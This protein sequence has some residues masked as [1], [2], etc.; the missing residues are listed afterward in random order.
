MLD[1][2]LGHRRP[3]VKHPLTRALSGVGLDTADV[4]TRLC[5]DPKTVQRW[6][7]G[8]V[9]YPRHRAAL[10]ELTGWTERDLWPQTH[11]PVDP[12]AAADEICTAYAHRSAVPANAWRHLFEHAKHEIGILAYSS[13]FL[14]EDAA[15]QCVL[16]DK[17]R[18]G[19]R[20]RIALGDAAGR[21]IA[22][23]GADEGIDTLVGARVRNALVLYRPL[24]IESGVELRLHDTTLYNSIYRADDNLLVNTH[25][26]GR[27][28][29]RSPVIHLRRM[30]DSGMAATYLDSFERVWT[31]AHAVEA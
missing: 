29:S 5:V 15:T 4:A 25:I 26:Y 20:I 17:A 14:A 3:P 10:V 11:Q 22:Q 31:S 18:A 27:P 13:L 21:H 16:R 9:P 19:I 23:R 24:A 30:S 28:A 7:A 6:M 8:R 12:E 1:S 2:Y